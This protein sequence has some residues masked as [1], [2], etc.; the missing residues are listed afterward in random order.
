MSAIQESTADKN[1]APSPIKKIFPGLSPLVILGI[2]LVLVPI[3]V[4]VTLDSIREQNH[5]IRERLIERGTFLIRSFEAGTRTGMR[6]KRWG[7]PR[8]QQLLVETALQPGVEYMMITDLNGKIF[9]HSDP[10][11]IGKYYKNMP[12][13]EKDNDPVEI[14]SRKVEADPEPK[15]FEVYKLFS[16]AHPRHGPGHR[17]RPDNLYGIDPTPDK[18][19]MEPSPEEMG[20]QGRLFQKMD[21]AR[22][23]LIIIAGL[24]LKRMELFK[25]RQIRRGVGRAAGLLFLGIAGMITLFAFQAYRAARSSFTRIKAFS[26]KVV[27]TMPAGLI[28]LDTDLNITTR[29]AMAI[30]IL[31]PVKGVPLE[32]PKEM[33]EPA[34]RVMTE[35]LTLTRETT[36]RSGKGDA[37]VLDLSVSPIREEEQEVT[38]CLLLFRDLTELAGLKQELERHRR[39]AAVGKLAAGVAHEIRNPLSSIK[40]FATYFKE[41]YQD[42]PE[43]GQTAD[44]MIHEVERLNRAVTQLLEFAGP[45][46]VT[47]REVSL[48]EIVH[49]SMKLVE[50]DLAGKGIRAETR[51]TTPMETVTTD[52]DR[53]NQILLNL[54]LNAIQAMDH[55]DTLNITVSEARQGRAL[56]IEVRDTGRG[57]DKKDLEHIFD[58]Y[59][60]TRSSGTG[61]GL[62]MVHSTVEALGGEISVTSQKGEGTSFVLT[63]PVT[64]GDRHEQ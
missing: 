30:Q 47:A 52:P 45:V 43:D 37:L 2:L 3:F 29:N 19:A 54:Y 33:R 14:F 55:G 58:P 53:I 1:S 36:C 28:T 11:K 6:T 25:K 48:K 60:T 23:D 63:I 51:I 46:R 64:P 57:I 17:M 20:C 32:L 61:L 35:S 34:R 27:D 15:V 9:A 62:A 42:N 50:G 44:I 10:A 38:G 41:R 39:L 8:T 5:R 49:H 13:W 22:Q 56:T 18:K 24:D 16:P 7:V 21:R 31:A 4:M 59:F 26:D 40:G 12:P